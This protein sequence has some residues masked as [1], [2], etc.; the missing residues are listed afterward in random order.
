[1]P[2]GSGDSISAGAIEVLANVLAIVGVLWLEDKGRIG[3]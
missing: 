3:A 2:R 1:M